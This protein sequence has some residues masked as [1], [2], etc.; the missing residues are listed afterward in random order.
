MGLLQRPF[1]APAM[2]AKEKGRQ[3]LSYDAIVLS[4]RLVRAQL[5]LRTQSPSSRVTAGWTLGGLPSGTLKI[6]PLN[7]AHLAST[8][9]SWEGPVTVALSRTLFCRA[10]A[11][12]E[13]L[14][15][16]TVWPPSNLRVKIFSIMSHNI[17]TTWNLL[18][19]LYRYSLP[20]TL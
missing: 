7:G 19:I 18:S 14:V 8:D 11:A 17:S 9:R 10:G 15:W 1:W 20:S 12:D 3:K 5:L 6:R 13:P 2:I 16:Q 4:T